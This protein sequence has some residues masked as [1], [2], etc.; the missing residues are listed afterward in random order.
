M[1]KGGLTLFNVGLGICG[2][3]AATQLQVLAPA[4][5]Q[6]FLFRQKLPQRRQQA[7]FAAASWRAL[8]YFRL[9]CSQ[10]LLLREQFFV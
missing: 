2:P 4:Q 8:V 6:L 10:L 9:Q 1:V 7:L 5:Q 3:K